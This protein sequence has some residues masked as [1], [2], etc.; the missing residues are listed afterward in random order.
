MYKLTKD[1][2]AET[3]TQK[4]NT[5]RKTFFFLFSF[6]FFFDRGCICEHQN[7]KDMSN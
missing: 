5:D 3:V 6:F 4:Y 1:H 2:K 7:H